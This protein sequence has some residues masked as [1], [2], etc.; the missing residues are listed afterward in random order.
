MTLTLD[1][2][3]D[4][5]TQVQADALLVGR[6]EN[7]PLPAELHALFGEAASDLLADV[8]GKTGEDVAVFYPRGEIGAKRLLIVGLGKE[9]KVT[10]ETIR[11][12]A[13]KGI[14]KAKSLGA[15]IVAT[16]LGQSSG[17][18]GSADATHAVVEAANLALYNYTLKQK[19]SDEPEKNVQTL[20]L[21]GTDEAAQRAAA[22]GQA[23]AS[24]VAQARDLV[25]GPPNIVD[26][27]FLARTAREIADSSPYIN[28][29]IYS[30]EEAREMG[31]GAF[32]AV[33][34]GSGTPP[35]FIVL[36]YR[37]QELEG[38]QPVGLVGKGIIFDT[39]GINIKPSTDLWKMKNDMGGGAAVLGTF[40]TL[41]N[42]PEPLNVPVVGIVP[43]TDNAIGGISFTPADVLTSLNGKTI[44]IQNTDAEGRLI[45]A[46]ALTYIDRYKPRAVV[47]LATLTGAIVVALGSNLTG[48]FANDE[49][50]ARRLEEGAE[51][52]GDEV[53]RMPLHKDYEKLIESDI[54]N[55]KN[56]SGRGGGAIGA[57][58]FLQH[59]IGDY[60][61]AHLD[62][63]GT[64]WGEDHKPKLPYNQK[65]ASG[66]GVRLLID[67]LQSYAAS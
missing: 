47:D 42:L 45:L 50:L 14:N 34:Q 54:A 4:P 22:L 2:S 35:Q 53:W 65:G 30:L 20:V 33:G 62:I 9:E 8:K 52:T 27:P 1:F 36:E 43:A 12:V 32:A 13:A 46:D 44:E 63:A 19:K 40:R 18:V 15:A 39:G 5:L 60:P 64:A 55:V 24:G 66:V 61:W 58:L 31:M 17:T 3:N 6:F 7:G 21:L 16:T 51:R 10:V 23:I 57:A 37:V 26:A 29:T 56:V 28:V 48:M 49:E 11:R 38:Q 25:N 41:A 67:L 59:F